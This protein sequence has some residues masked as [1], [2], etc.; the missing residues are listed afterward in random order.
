M[1][2]AGNCAV[3][4]DGAFVHPTRAGCGEREWCCTHDAPLVS[5]CTDG[6]GICVPAVSACPDEWNPVYTSC[7]EGDGGTCCMPDEYSCPAYPKGCAD[8]GGI[9]TSARW[10]MCPESTEPYNLESDQGGCER[11][12]GGWC[13][14][15][16]PPSS[17]SDTP[18]V[19]CVPGD[20]C[21]GCFDPATDTDLACEAGRVCCM[22]TCRDL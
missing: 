13:C 1:L 21:E 9:C 14:V 22:D 18:G 15:E 16:A 7:G 4:P 10:Q 8:V 19:M 11:P 20:Q 5:D 3:C 12:M 2:G 17:C 6:G